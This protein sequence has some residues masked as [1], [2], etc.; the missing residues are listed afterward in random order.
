MTSDQ[1]KAAAALAPPW[2]DDQRA[3]ATAILATRPHRP[4]LVHVRGR[5]RLDC[6]C[7]SSGLLTM[8]P[9]QGLGPVLEAMRRHRAGL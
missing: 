4:V 1:A 6:T 9:T 3:R 2:T 8:A 5:V 7:G